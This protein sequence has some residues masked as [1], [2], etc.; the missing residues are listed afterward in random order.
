MACLPSTSI[1][2]VTMSHVL[3]EL[4]EC[5]EEGKAWEN[6]GMKEQAMESSN[7]LDLYPE[8]EC[9]ARPQAR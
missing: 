4:K 5:L 8:L 7:S 1:Q 3:M 6:R 2:R 9:E